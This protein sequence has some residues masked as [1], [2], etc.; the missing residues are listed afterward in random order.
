MHRASVGLLIGITLALGHAS[1]AKLRAQQPMRVSSARDSVMP[2][3]R[4]RLL[5]VFDAATGTALSNAEVLDVRTGTSHL[6]NTSGLVALDFIPDGGALVRIRKLGFDPVTR[7][8]AISP[9]DTTPVTET[10][11]PS[12]QR[13]P[14]VSIQDSSPKY[15]SPA[16]RE[17][18]ERRHLGFG[19]F[20]AEAELRKKDNLSFPTVIS[21]LPGLMVSCYSRLSPWGCVAVSTRLVSKMAFSVGQPCGISVYQ[22]GIPL[23]SVQDRDLLKMATQ[24][25]AGVEFYA[26]AAEIP[27]QYNAT[28]NACGVLLLWTRER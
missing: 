16:L 6:T 19:H 26:G 1:G 17:F 20:I 22:D 13:L 15:L 3:Y 25:Y 9:Q 8:V 18:E 10:L 28:G 2:R 24:N 11:T 23:Q 4:L 21:G 27:V 7:F 14:G 5:G 12:V